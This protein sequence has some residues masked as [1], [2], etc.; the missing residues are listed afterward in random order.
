MCVC[1]QESVH[2]LFTLYVYNVC[3]YVCV[4]DGLMG[5]KQRK[6]NG[7]VLHV[8]MGII[9]QYVWLQYSALV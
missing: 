1:P 7:I 8:R 6:E 5:L 3:M 4:D 2:I 9:I